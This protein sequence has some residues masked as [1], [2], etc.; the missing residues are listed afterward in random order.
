[1]KRRDEFCDGLSELKRT[2]AREARQKIADFEKAAPPGWRIYWHWGRTKAGE[3]KVNLI[4]R[5]P[6]AS[7][8]VPD[9]SEVMQIFGCGCDHVESEPIF[10]A[11]H[12]GWSYWVV[13]LTPQERSVKALLLAPRPKCGCD[14]WLNS[15]AS[16]QI[17][18]GVR[19]WLELLNKSA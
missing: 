6:Y 5:T 13:S 16:R 19:V 15:S 7:P 17:Y 3:F 18:D 12:P 14:P 1:M 9:K 8:L 10:M 4:A 2:Q 11:G